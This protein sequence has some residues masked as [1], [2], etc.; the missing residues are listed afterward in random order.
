[1]KQSLIFFLGLFF[2]TNCAYKPRVPKTKTPPVLVKLAIGEKLEDH[3]SSGD[4]FALSSQGV[5]TSKAGKKMFDL[6]GNIV[7]AFVS[8]SFTISVERPHSTGLGGGGF[9]LFDKKG[10]KTPFAVDFREMAPLSAH[11]KMYLDKNGKVIPRKSLEGVFSGGVPGFVKGVLEIHKKFGTLPLKTVLAPA[12]KL[13]RSGFKI[14]PELANALKVKKEILKKFPATEKIFFHNGDVYKLGDLLVQTDLAKTIK[15][16]AKKGASVFYEGEIA[17][18]IV[19]HNKKY[20]GL[21]GLEDLK[22]YEVKWRAPITGT[23]KGH[24]IFSMPPPSSGGVHVVQILNILENDKLELYGPHHPKSIHLTASSMQAAFAD[25]SVYLG[26]SDFVEV[27]IVGLTS[28]KYAKD[29][30]YDI[31]ESTSLNNFG[32]KP[33]NPKKFEESTHTTHFSIVDKD[34][35]MIVSTQTI[36]GYFGSGMVIDGTGIVL[37]NEMDDFST[38]VGAKNLYKAVG[39]KK[40]LVEAKKRPLS[41]MSPT[42]VRKDGVPIMG[43]GSPSGT[44]IIT[45]VTLSLLNYLEH[46]LS[47]YDSVAALRYHHQW[48]PNEIRVEEHASLPAFTIKKLRKMRHELNF[49]DF[50]CRVQAVAIKNGKLKAV[51]DPRGAGLAIG[52]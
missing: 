24:E 22:N 30:R 8:M 47:L 45:C 15:L 52:Q 23:Y 17:K 49:K 5:A 6:G 42:I 9:M 46:K 18:K 12:I 40:N 34:S 4:D 2:L 26:D 19:A 7:D 37:N 14:Y 39:S 25:R 35:N 43:T 48:F 11:S 31:P 28:K 38:K 32:R 29:L 20:N 41:S 21:I 1:M 27:P 51:S 36:N 13:A 33:G 44:R 10:E 50:G 3:Q 16:I